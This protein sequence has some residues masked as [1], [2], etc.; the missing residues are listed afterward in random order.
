MASA[1]PAKVAELSAMLDGVAEVV[2][3]PEGLGDVV[4][5]GDTL[6]ANALIKARAVAQFAAAPAVADDTGL[7]V[8][9]LHG[10]PGVHSARYSGGG[11]ADNVAK[12][13]AELAALGPEADRSAEFRTVVAL[14]HPNGAERVFQGTCA[15]RIVETATGDGGFGY[16]PVFVPDD[17]D[18]RTFAQMDRADKAK[19]S[20]RGR[21]L[22]ALAAELG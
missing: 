2:A 17:G 3:R 11:D 18:G 4:E 8:E 12:L 6:E 13:L 16:D 19:I 9:A 5:D 22:A 1:N 20:H 14:V 7:F 10:Q 15:G 21:A